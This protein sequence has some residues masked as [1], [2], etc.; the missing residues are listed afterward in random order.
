MTDNIF[1]KKI[2]DAVRRKFEEENKRNNPPNI[3]R[4]IANPRPVLRII[5]Q[6]LIPWWRLYKS[7]EKDG[8]FDNIPKILKEAEQK[9]E[10]PPWAV[11][12]GT[13]L[14]SITVQVQ[15]LQ[16]KYDYFQALIKFTDYLAGKLGRDLNNG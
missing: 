13:K 6:H 2:T 14:A 8:W 7:L 12:Y 10:I 3:F 9:G 15:N 1:S 5:P 16:K 4:T 11:D